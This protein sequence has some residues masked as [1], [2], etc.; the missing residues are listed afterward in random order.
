M[1]LDF[2]TGAAIGAGC[3]APAIA[4]LWRGWSAVSAENTATAYDLRTERTGAKYSRDRVC[5]LS[6]ECAAAN[7]RIATLTN[8]RGAVQAHLDAALGHIVAIEP[9]AEK[10]RKLVARRQA[11]DLARKV[12]RVKV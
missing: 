3:M 11:Q 10:G 1:M 8:Q 4:Y 12:A 2:A 7:A 5:K 6:R 9:L